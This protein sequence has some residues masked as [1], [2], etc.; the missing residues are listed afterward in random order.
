MY[1]RANYH[2]GVMWFYEYLFNVC[3]I[4]QFIISINFFDEILNQLLS[5]GGHFILPY[6]NVSIDM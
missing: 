5:D 4:C 2:D 3:D 6:F 1:S